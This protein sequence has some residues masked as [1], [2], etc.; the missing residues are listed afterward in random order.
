[1][2]LLHS[3]LI[4]LSA[5]GC[6]ASSASHPVK[7]AH[8]LVGDQVEAVARTLSQPWLDSG[9]HLV[10]AGEAAYPAGLHDLGPAAPLMLWVRGEIPDQPCVAIVGSRH[11]TP[12]GAEVT[13]VLAEAAVAAGAAV[14]SG[15]ATGIDAAAHRATLKAGGRTIV[16]LAGGAGRIYPPEN[17]DLLRSAMACGA[18]VWEFPESA[19]LRKASFLVRNRMIAATA[20]ATVLAEAAERSGAL[21]TGR[22]A[23]DLGRLVLGVPGPIGRLTS[24][25]VN[26]AIADGWAMILL[27]PDDLA[28]MLPGRPRSS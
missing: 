6:D 28:A 17:S 4:V 13:G 24:A 5:A 21:N 23:A 19:P 22:T 1:M 7:A 2:D 18:V 15:G 16:Y 26:R 20:Q 9:G 27:G 12:Y 3:S 11:C 8:D 14:I 25:G 10:F